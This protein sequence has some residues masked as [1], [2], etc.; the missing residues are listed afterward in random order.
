MKEAVTTQYGRVRLSAAVA[1][2]LVRSFWIPDEKRLRPAVGAA[3]DAGYYRRLK[4]RAARS[5]F[6]VG[7][8]NNAHTDVMPFKN[9]GSDKNARHGTTVNG[10]EYQPSS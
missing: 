5:Q 2:E 6:H 4:T 9:S 1:A 10:T 8:V 7:Y 3:V